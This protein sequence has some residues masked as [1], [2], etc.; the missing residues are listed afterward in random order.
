M[1]DEARAPRARIL[2]LFGSRVM[3][4][5]ERENIE[6]L[7][8][9]RR[10]GAEVLCLVRHESWNV[11]VP[12]A[13]QARGLA[14]ARAPY[15]D[16][17]LAGWRLWILL[18]N[19]FA[20]I[21]GNWR[22]LRAVRAFQPTHIHAFNPFY[23]ASFLPALWLV[24]APLIYRAGDVPVRHRWVW[25]QIWR[26]VVRR[27]ERFLSVS[28][29]IAAALE[30]SGVDPARIT[31][32]CGIA[33]RRVAAVPQP[34]VPSSGPADFVF[35]GQI[36][37]DKG[38]DVLIEAIARVAR[39]HA[40]CRL[41]VAGRI[42]ENDASDAWARAL[43]DRVAADAVLRD[44]VVFTGFIEDV[45]ALLHRRLALVVPSQIDEALGL[46]VLEAKAAGLPAIVSPKGGLPELVQSGIDG[47]VC[48]DSSAASLADALMSYASD[49]ATAA[50]HGAAALE[51]LSKFSAA[52]FEQ[53]CATAFALYSA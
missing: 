4:G 6:M 10:R 29:F 26:L 45:P 7:S 40:T 9:L 27:T 32:I 28:R 51:S 24:R 22:L 2:S 5:A 20:F 15:L 30:A 47:I 39:T 23:V 48:A 34:D 25:R 3:F 46:V 42:T 8:A 11:A 17:W 18:R 33:P 1:P 41:I 52:E 43:R 37:P 38:A 35:V 19:P 49:P 13:L 50:R 53:K 16:G 12:A 44:R 14:V 36:I 31:V 21:A